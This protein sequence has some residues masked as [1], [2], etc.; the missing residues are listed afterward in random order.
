MGLLLSAGVKL[1]RSRCESYRDSE[2][3]EGKYLV[4]TKYA[5]IWDI[6]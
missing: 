1:K 2:K 6:F 5:N 4:S 3:W